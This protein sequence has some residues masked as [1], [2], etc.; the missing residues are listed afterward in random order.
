MFAA[1]SGGSRA[2]VKHAAT[3]RRTKFDGIDT[4]V[5]SLL[6]YLTP[7]GNVVWKQ[8]AAYPTNS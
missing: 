5:L 8:S 2:A 6:L 7:L 1:A 4:S 3:Q